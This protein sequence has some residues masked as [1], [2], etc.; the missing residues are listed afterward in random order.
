MCVCVCL[1]VCNFKVAQNGGEGVSVR[2][3]RRHKKVLHDGM[4]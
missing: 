2:S 4:N 1:C 3:K